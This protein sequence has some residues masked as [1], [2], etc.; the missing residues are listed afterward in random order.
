MIFFLGFSFLKEIMFIQEKKNFCLVL[1]GNKKTLFSFMGQTQYIFSSPYELKRKFWNLL[2]NDNHQDIKKLKKLINSKVNINEYHPD[3]NHYPITYCIEKRKLEYTKI[4]IEYKADLQKS[5]TNQYNCLL[6]ACNTRHKEIIELLI[7]NMPQYYLE[8]ALEYTVRYYMFD[9]AKIIIEYLDDIPD[10]LYEVCKRKSV[11]TVRYLLEEKK[12]NIKHNLLNKALRFGTCSDIIK[13]LVNHG[14][15]VDNNTDINSAVKFDD[16]ET[17]EF[18]IENKA[19]VNN[20]KDSKTCLSYAIQRQNHEMLK[21]LLENKADPNIQNGTPILE[22]YQNKDFKSMKLLL[23]YKANPDTMVNH[24]FSGRT[25]YEFM[26]HSNTISLFMK[27]VIDFNQDA[28]KLL[29]E[30]KSD[31]H[32]KFYVNNRY[33]NPIIWASEDTIFEDLIH[34]LLENG[35]DINDVN[36]NHVK[37]LKIFINRRN[38][39]WPENNMTF[40]TKLLDVEASLDVLKSFLENKDPNYVFKNNGDS[41]LIHSVRKN[42]INAVKA[43]LYKKANVNVVDQKDKSLLEIAS[44]I[45]NAEILKLLLENGAT[46]V[47]ETTTNLNTAIKK[48]D[49]QKVLYLLKKGVKPDHQNIL[50]YAAESKNEEMLQLASKIALGQNIFEEN[51]ASAPEFVDD[52]TPSAPPYEEQEEGVVTFL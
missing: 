35:A 51:T 3:Y 10:I 37:N 44:N 26:K 15:V 30:H 27:S 8:H 1:D 34:F 50:K 46:F 9:I 48:G 33:I 29:L 2:K 19:N 5:C 32:K 28:I 12:V 11:E 20:Q 25:I 22:T 38:I 39:K 52:N 47:L 21:L 7:Q 4:L 49:I 17:V 18:L 36:L 6:L 16:I 24:C 40:F 13:I 41:L 45:G 14:A 23:E 43:L 31:I 42:N